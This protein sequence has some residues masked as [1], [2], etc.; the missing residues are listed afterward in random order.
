MAK[1]E[2]LAIYKEKMKTELEKGNHKEARKY[3]ELLEKAYKELTG[4]E[5]KEMLQGNIKDYNEYKER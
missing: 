2:A 4:K 5:L 3:Y 1:L